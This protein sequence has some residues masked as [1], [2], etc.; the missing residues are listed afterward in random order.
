[1]VKPFYSL[2]QDRR[3]QGKVIHL[4]QCQGEDEIVG[5]ADLSGLVLPEEQQLRDLLFM[6]A[7]KAR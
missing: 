6:S 2:A 5:V 3:I 7:H 1:V 4:A